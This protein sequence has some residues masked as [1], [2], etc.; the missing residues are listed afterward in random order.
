MKEILGIINQ[1]AA[2]SGSNDKKKVINDFKDYP[3]FYSVVKLALDQGKAYG[4]TEV[5]HKHI[6]KGYASTEILLSEINNMSKKRGVTDAEA[7]QLAS[8]IQD[9]ATEAVVNMI[10]K[11]DLRCGADAKT[12]NSVVPG[13]VYEVPYQR[14][15]A[16]KH[17]KN[18]DF[19]SYV[20]AQLKQDGMFAYLDSESGKFTS[21]NGKTF[22]LAPIV[23]DLDR[24]VA[25]LN[26]RALKP[27]DVVLIGELQVTGD[28]G[29][30][31]PR[32]QANGIFN[33][34]ISGEGKPEY[35]DKLVYMIWDYVPKSSF[36][37]KKCSLKYADKLKDLEKVGN[38]GHIRMVKTV[39]VS[40]YEKAMDFYRKARSKKEEGAIIK[41]AA[42]L[43]WKDEQSGTKYGVKLKAEA[44]AEFR[45]VKAY[46]GAN[47]KKY[48]HLM[49][50]LTVQS[51][52][53]KIVTDV[54]MGFS[55]SE[56][57]LGVDW[58]NSQA[59]KIVSVKFTDVVTDKSSR[60]TFC[61]E[62][63]RFDESRFNEKDTADTYKYCMEQ[64]EH[65]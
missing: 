13:W 60:E 35:N 46:Y 56:R 37:A 34:F 26:Q 29:K 3:F 6:G 31:L 17:I 59:S 52:D 22:S 18:I 19:L 65:A 21:R 24:T 47:G 10:L 49:G 61:L 55:D 63:A 38:T 25:I 16:F 51:E 20:V 30:F 62:H 7:I 50:G 2:T 54:G 44:V 5:P 48:E 45:I 11:K 41:D 32:K 58:W 53:G 42:E 1:I 40:S 8:L 64:L 57:E 33:S 15:K 12:F 36:L 39:Q 4:L 43:V 23:E 14:Y 28:N 9:E 27:T